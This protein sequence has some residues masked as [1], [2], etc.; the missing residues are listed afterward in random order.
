MIGV[1]YNTVDVQVQ[2][3]YLSQTINELKYTAENNTQ[4]A[5]AATG[6]LRRDY[7]VFE[8]TATLSVTLMTYT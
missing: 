2:V 1:Q 6:W 8:S 4:Y 5:M 3:I 7:L